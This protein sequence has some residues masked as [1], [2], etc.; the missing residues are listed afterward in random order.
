MT[1][2][3]R[4]VSKR[5]PCEICGHHDWCTYTETVA[6]CTRISNGSFRTARNGTY[7]HRTVVQQREDPVHRSPS[8]RAAPRASEEQLGR[9][10]RALLRM[11]PLSAAHKQSLRRRG[12]DDAAIEIN[13]YRSAPTEAQA[14]AITPQLASLGLEGIPGFYQEGGR[15]RVVKLRPGILAP[16][17]N[18]S[19]LIVGIQIRH[20]SYDA[21]RPKYVWLSSANRNCG[22]S[23]DAPIHWAKPELLASAT[24]VLLTEG[25]LKADVISQ[26]LSVPAIAAAGVGLFGRDFGVLLKAHHP[27]I[28]AVICFDSDWRTKLQV[29]CA[30]TA[31]QRQL[32]AASVLWRV[33]CWPIKFKGYD[34]FLLSILPTEVAA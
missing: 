31:L 19:G 21:C 20:D 9:V 15:W 26:V 1:M 28:T 4:R 24:E 6:F 30:L 2:N 16:V 5:R 8:R 23:S 12:L 22:T 17:R 25:G 29:K 10:Y 3:F 13:G 14:R 32:T 7:M 11:L 27:N 18:R 34:D 33:R